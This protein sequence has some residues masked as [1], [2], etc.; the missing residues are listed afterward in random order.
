[1]SKQQVQRKAATAAER[2][3]D[4]SKTNTVASAIVHSA[5]VAPAVP[6]PLETSAPSGDVFVCGLGRGKNF[7]MPVDDSGVDR[8]GHSMFFLDALSTLQLFI[9][10]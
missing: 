3:A 5:I 8:D 1:M 2:A 4:T 6:V 7:Y 10:K 9:S